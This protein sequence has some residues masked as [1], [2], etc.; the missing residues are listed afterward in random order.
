[1]DPF[2]Q[3][4]LTASAALL[5]WPAVVVYLF[6]RKPAGSALIWAVLGAL[7]LLPAQMGIK[8]PM[9][10]VIDKNSVASLSAVVG[11]L[12]FCRE[13][14]KVLRGSAILTILT[15]AYVVS[16]VV[17]SALNN[18]TIVIGNTVLP[19]VGYY[20]GFSALLSQ[21]IFFAPY[22]LGRRLLRNELQNFE[23]LKAF[24]IGGTLITL[25]MLFEI[26]MSPQLSTWI[27]GYFPSSFPVEI[28]YGGFR[29]VIFFNNGLSAAFFLSGA[30][31]S[32]VSLWRLK[33]ACTLFSPGV[34][35]TYL[36]VVLALCKS[37]GAFIYALT[38]A[39]L[40]RWTKPQTQIRLAVLL[41]V[42]SISYPI[43]RL[44]SIFP[45]GLVLSLSEELNE[46]RADSL[47]FR[48]D[49]EDALLSHASERLMF[50]WGRFGRNRVYWSSGSDA[51]VT[52]GRWII[53]LGQYGLLGFIAQFGLLSFPV[54]RSLIALR[55]VSKL[56]EQLLLSSLALLVGI[57]VL[58]Q[59]PNDSLTP[60][61]WLLAGALLGRSE[62]I[63]QATKNM[64]E[65]KKAHHLFAWKQAKSVNRQGL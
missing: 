17:T 28:R 62:Y 36:G 27:Y 65:E 42:I 52:D 43:L 10:P 5:I 29:P 59:L 61:S 56:E 12:C 37:A 8:F 45:T 51:S 30:C 14:R 33:S 55:R 50:G 31:I 46:Q 58:E 32:A 19:G 9:I 63:C 53:T 6:A 57:T 35:T 2:D 13:P 41:A 39:P 60:W 34:L 49:Q 23:L 38:I 1:M 40:V 21:V 15:V 22:L 26:R 54:F 64:T 25:P 3:A 47:K 48:F 4:S 24:V 16:P 20:D 11:W 18:D 44:T 7:L